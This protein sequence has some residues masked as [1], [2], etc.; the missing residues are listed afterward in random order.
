MDSTINSRCVPYALTLYHSV[1]LHLF[2]W[3]EE[4]KT[5]FK[6]IPIN[7]INIQQAQSQKKKNKIVLIKGIISYSNFF[8]C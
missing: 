3:Q 8:F 1:Q 7:M 6:G 5:Y 4:K 2:Q